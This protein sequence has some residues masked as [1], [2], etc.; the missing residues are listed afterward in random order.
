[1][2]GSVDWSCG[3][4]R[5]EKGGG[6]R[7]GEIRRGGTNTE[8]EGLQ[9][10]CSHSFLRKSVLVSNGPGVEGEFPVVGSGVL[11]AGIRKVL[12]YR[13]GVFRSDLEVS[14]ICCQC[15]P[16]CGRSYTSW[17]V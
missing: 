7:V 5:K 8:L 11:D 9:A 4:Q 1:M 16:V 13:L 6:G 15:G 3:G 10:G 2:V 17:T 12:Q 14:D